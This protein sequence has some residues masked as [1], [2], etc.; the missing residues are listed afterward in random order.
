MIKIF[1]QYDIDLDDDN[2]LNFGDLLKNM[3]VFVK[4]LKF[5]A[6]FIQNKETNQVNKYTDP[7]KV[8]ITLNNIELFTYAT[9][10]TRF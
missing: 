1:H 4:H 7:Q 9:P 6:D 2:K 3:L 8:L 10:F 5:L